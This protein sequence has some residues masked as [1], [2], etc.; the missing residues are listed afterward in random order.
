MY[1]SETGADSYMAAESNG[2]AKGVNFRAQAIAVKNILEDVLANKEVGSG[3][4]VFQFTDGWWKAGNPERQDKG[5]WAPFSSGVP[6]DG[7]PNEEHWGIVDIDRRKKPVFNVVKQA[8]T[9]E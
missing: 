3:V 6:Y 4:A 8:F 9:A 7:S 5:G 1:L 2:H